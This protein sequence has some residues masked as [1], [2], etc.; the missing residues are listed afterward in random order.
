MPAAV[1]LPPGPSSHL[2]RTDLP[3]GSLSHNPYSA[4]DR[5]HESALRNIDRRVE[6][7]PGREPSL[8][9]LSNGRGR[10]KHRWSTVKLREPDDKSEAMLSYAAF[11]A[12]YGIHLDECQQP[13]VDENRASLTCDRLR[14]TDYYLPQAQYRS[15][16]Q[17]TVKPTVGPTEQSQ[18]AFDGSKAA[19]TTDAASCMV[20][21]SRVDYNTVVDEAGTENEPADKTKPRE[22][23]HPPRRYRRKASGK[24]R[25]NDKVKVNKDKEINIRNIPTYTR[26]IRQLLVRNLS[27]NVD[28]DWLC[29][30]FEKF[31][32]VTGCFIV[33]DHEYGG[34]KGY[35]KF[36]S[37]DAA[38]TA[39]EEMDGYVLD[40]LALS[41]TFSTPHYISPYWSFAEASDPGTAT[42]TSSGPELGS[43]EGSDCDWPVRTPQDSS[44]DTDVPSPMRE[45]D[46]CSPRKDPK[47]TLREVRELLDKKAAQHGVTLPSKEQWSQYL[48][49]WPAGEPSTRA[50]TPRSMA[51]E[52]NSEQ[53]FE[54]ALRTL[55]LQ[56]Y[57]SVDHAT[58]E[59]CFCNTLRGYPEISHQLV[60]A[61]TTIS[62]YQDKHGW[63]LRLHWN[64]D[65]DAQLLEFLEQGVNFGATNHE[66]HRA[67]VRL[68]T[69]PDDCYERAK[70]LRF[71]SSGW[72]EEEDSRLLNMKTANA[73]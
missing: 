29:S 69:I 66:A 56:R 31:G 19:M 16:V 14:T 40:G 9:N 26:G 68:N 72:T 4:N 48:R 61:F 21:P 13:I 71:H 11:D 18:G 33:D 44:E 25:N 6:W 22:R 38:A 23:S 27:C 12:A 49:R 45:A 1:I 46:K 47:V 55:S 41:V 5:V 67:A 34:D 52:V 42:S 58:L 73:S 43:D 30:E 17:P 24:A 65:L 20:K 15:M 62:N 10:T 2:P 37:A 39:Q 53:S 28:D 59:Y 3:R 7:I 51:S 8:D 60:A 57:R 32:T 63:G 64:H 50:P 70:H 35:V 36:Q 54:D